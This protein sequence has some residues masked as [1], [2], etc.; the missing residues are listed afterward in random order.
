MTTLSFPDQIKMARLPLHYF[1]FNNLD[2]N[3]HSY[4]A[5]QCNRLSAKNV[6]TFQ[7]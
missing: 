2:F 4:I 3:F 1:F 6:L 7:L 5:I